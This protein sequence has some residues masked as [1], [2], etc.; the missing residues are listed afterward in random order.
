MARNKFR[1]NDHVIGAMGSV[2]NK[3]GNVTDTGDDFGTPT[4]TV[5][6]NDGSTDVLP[7]NMIS[8]TG[9]CGRNG[10]TCRGN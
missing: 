6:W 5:Q 10:S 8:G 3:H 9:M 4:A 1:E 2:K 7:E